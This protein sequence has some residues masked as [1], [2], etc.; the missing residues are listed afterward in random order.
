MGRKQEDEEETYGVRKRQIAAEI[1]KEAGRQISKL[2]R[3]A[4]RV[5]AST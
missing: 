3:W 5:H 2:Y 4:F 1:G